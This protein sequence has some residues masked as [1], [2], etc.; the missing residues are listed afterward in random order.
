MV[1]QIPLSNRPGTYAL[2]DEDDF[3]YLSQFIWTYSQ[4]Y[5]RRSKRRKEPDARNLS[6]HRIVMDCPDGLTVDH[7]NFNKLDNRKEN[8]RIVTMKQNSAHQ[9]KNKA[10]YERPKK[11]ERMYNFRYLLTKREIAA[12]KKLIEQMRKSE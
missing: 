2:V 10:L 7:I 6:M 4:G 8:L 11:K 9:P 3:E 1:R 12:I 5:A